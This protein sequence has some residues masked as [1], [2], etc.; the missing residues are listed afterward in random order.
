MSLA[1]ERA[2]EIAHS[3]VVIGAA[4]LGERSFLAQGAVIRSSG[5]GVVIGTGSAVLE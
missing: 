5:T 4:R 2:P 3:A 1:V